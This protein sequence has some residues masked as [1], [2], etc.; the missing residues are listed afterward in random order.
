M[1]LTAGGE[2][3]AP[4]T[5]GM[6]E[7]KMPEFTSDQVG[8]ATV[9]FTSQAGI[10]ATILAFVLIAVSAA[11]A[12]HVRA[13]RRQIAE[14]N[15]SWIKAIEKLS[16]GWGEQT[17]GWGKRMDQFRA[18]IKEAF[19]Q[20]DAIADKVVDALHKL[21]VEIARVGARRERD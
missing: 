15:D 10:A 18:D 4:A 19:N 2:A 14:L 7:M 12:W 8:S 6:G 20:N 17:E 1:R 5:P 3:P 21:T 11:F 13:S 9:W 16:K